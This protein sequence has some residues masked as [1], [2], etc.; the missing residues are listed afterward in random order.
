MKSLETNPSIRKAISVLLLG[1]SVLTG[2]VAQEHPGTVSADKLVAAVAK[3]DTGIIL[4]GLKKCPRV[5]SNSHGIEQSKAPTIE[6]AQAYIGDPNYVDSQGNNSH[7]YAAH[8][9]SQYVVDDNKSV[10]VYCGPDNHEN[11]ASFSGVM[12][13]SATK[14]DLITY[15]K[16]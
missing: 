5:R 2:C 1:S 15:P 16:K 13:V 6:I 11:G 4:E 3:G 9:T 8:L 10:Q 7:L 14:P 12:L